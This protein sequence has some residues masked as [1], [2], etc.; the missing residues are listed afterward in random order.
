VG[1]ELRERQESSKGIRHYGFPASYWRHFERLPRLPRGVL[2]VADA[3]CRFNPVYGQGMASAAKQARLLQTVLGQ[4]AAEPDPLAAAQAGFM[5]EVDSVLQSPWSMSTNADLAFPET[6]GD[7][8]ENF[9][10]GQQFEAALFRAAVD[11]PVVHRALI[12][13]IQLLRPQDVFN[14]P[15]IRERIEAAA[16]TS[17]ERSSN[18]R[19]ACITLRTSAVLALSGTAGCHGRCPLITGQLSH[20]YA[21]S[22][23]MVREQP[24]SPQ[25]KSTLS[26][27]R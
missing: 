23:T 14:E 15:H 19:C 9:E 26:T 1:A 24:S 18:A 17:L 6:R 21:P 2:P 11:D 12:E 7:R 16:K 10:E 5:A 25:P 22:V 8:P 20:G 27:A 4:V 13:V 3:F